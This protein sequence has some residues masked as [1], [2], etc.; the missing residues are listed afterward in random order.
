MGGK[1]DRSEIPSTKPAF[2]SF[3]VDPLD[4]VWVMRTTAGPDTEN[5]ILDVFDRDRLRTELAAAEAGFER[6]VAG[7]KLDGWVETF[8]PNGM[9]IQPDGPVVGHEGIRLAMSG[10]FADSTFRL[11]WTPDLIGVSDDGTLG[12]T[13]GRY[14]RRRVV[15]GAETAQVAVTSLSGAAS[16]T[17]AG[18]WRPTWAPSPRASWTRTRPRAHRARD[19]LP[20]AAPG[21][22]FPTTPRSPC[23]MVGSGLPAPRARGSDR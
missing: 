18:S 13:T 22:R 21:C 19:A 9:M 4:R 20:Q 16:R 6:A 17:A 23:R 8:A 1:I 14:E 5:R 3:F 10:A 7:R 2:D 11:T 15:D 12:Y